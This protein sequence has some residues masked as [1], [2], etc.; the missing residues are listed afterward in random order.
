[1]AFNDK[2]EYDFGVI[3]LYKFPDIRQLSIQNFKFTIGKQ[4]F[5]C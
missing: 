1:M 4:I 3:V 2:K 5:G